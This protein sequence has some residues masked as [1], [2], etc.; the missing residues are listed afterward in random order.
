[1][2]ESDRLVGADVLLQRGGK[3][4]CVGEEGEAPGVK[5]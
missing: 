4:G 3:R 2:G 5:G 1:L